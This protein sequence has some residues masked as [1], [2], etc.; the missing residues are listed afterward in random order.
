MRLHIFSKQLSNTVF[1]FEIDAA[2]RIL[3]PCGTPDASHAAFYF[4]GFFEVFNYSKIMKQ[5]LESL[6]QKSCR[7]SHAHWLHL[8]PRC[9]ERVTP[10]V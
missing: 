5:R 4:E 10:F 3:Y 8:L 9:V 6:S 7:L 2:L 1:Q